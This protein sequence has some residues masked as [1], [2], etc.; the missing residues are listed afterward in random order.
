MISP[1][2]RF[3][4]AGAFAYSPLA[5]KHYREDLYIVPKGLAVALEPGVSVSIEPGFVYNG[6]DVP[7]IVWSLIPPHGSYSAA[8][9][10]HDKLC[11]TLEVWKDGEFV[12][13]TR[14]QADH[15]FFKCL[16]V[17]G[18]SALKYHTIKFGVSSYRVLSFTNKPHVRANKE[19]IQELALAEFME[20]ENLLNGAF[21]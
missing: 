1:Y 5:S 12:K 7:R 4:G 21:E 14:K 20:Y 15:Y 3:Y 13:I 16:R 6:A 8:V 2:P 19:H 10:V 18:V 11:E 9:Q 17:L